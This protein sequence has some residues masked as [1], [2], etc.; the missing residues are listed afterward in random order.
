MRLCASVDMFGTVNSWKSLDTS[1]SVKFMSGRRKSTPRACHDDMP[2]Y[3]FEESSLEGHPEQTSS[4]NILV[5][6]TR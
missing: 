5:D 3:A 2:E 1:S 6:L 4:L